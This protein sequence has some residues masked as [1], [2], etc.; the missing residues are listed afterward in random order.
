[1]FLF[2]LH[3]NNLSYQFID[4]QLSQNN[5]TRF[6]AK[7]NCLLPIVRTNYGQMTSAFS[8]ISFWNS[9]SAELKSSS[10]FSFKHMLKTF[11]LVVVV[12]MMFI[13]GWT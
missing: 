1:M 11:L 3:V 8:A 13:D 2:Q 6:A 10:F 7:K 4:R 9:L 12:V 5:S